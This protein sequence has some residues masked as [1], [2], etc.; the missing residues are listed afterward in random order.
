MDVERIGG[1]VDRDPYGIGGRSGGQ[2]GA[3]HAVDHRQLDHRGHH[4]HS[5]QGHVQDLEG[6]QAFPGV[7]PDVGE[8]DHQDEGPGL[9]DERPPG[10]AD[11]GG[12][13]VSPEPDHQHDHE[14]DGGG[15]ADAEVVDGEAGQAVGQAIIAGALAHVAEPFDEGTEL[16]GAADQARDQDVG[17]HDDPD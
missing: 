5:A 12:E 8:D 14:Q 3:G 9:D 1:G 6:T 2:D 7:V 4:Q 16:G 13:E 17:R 15:G 11:Q 10:D